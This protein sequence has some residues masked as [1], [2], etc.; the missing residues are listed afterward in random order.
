MFS[1]Y[2]S[3]F[4]VIL[5]EI[6]LFYIVSRETTHKNLFN[7]LK[8][9]L[10]HIFFLTTEEPPENRRS[11]CL[12]VGCERERYGLYDKELPLNHLLIVTVYNILFSSLSL[13]HVAS[14]PDAFI[15][16]TACSIVFS[17]ILKSLKFAVN[18]DFL[19]NFSVIS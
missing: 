7:V 1:Q 13:L 18:T 15:V 8:I 14:I 16:S 10:V 4:T 19:G 3:R 6:K 17:N 11:F 5:T 12:D 2:L 9:I